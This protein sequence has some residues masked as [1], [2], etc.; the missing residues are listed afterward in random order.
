MANWKNAKDGLKGRQIFGL[1][2]FD[3]KWQFEA[4]P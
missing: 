3:L 2:K 4:W 1:N